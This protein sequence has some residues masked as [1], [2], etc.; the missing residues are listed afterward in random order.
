MDS[1]K[2]WF[3][4]E[5]I[6]KRKYYYELDYPPTSSFIQEVV[7]TIKALPTQKI[8]YSQEDIAC[9]HR[10]LDNLDYIESNAKIL[11]Q[12]D[13]SECIKKRR[14]WIESELTEASAD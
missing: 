1:L 13:G 8:V 2:A 10:I 6:L 5:V 3:V 9:M 7:K 4:Y 11:G 12:T 14:D